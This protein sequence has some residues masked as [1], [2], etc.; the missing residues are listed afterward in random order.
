MARTDRVNDTARNS[1]HWESLVRAV[2][3]L[4][5][6]KYQGSKSERFE[7]GCFD[8]IGKQ[9]GDR[10]QTAEWDAALKRELQLPGIGMPD[11]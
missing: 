5:S 9:G 11:D 10:Q 3:W 4:W 6:S 1:L 8:V 2:Q 7:N